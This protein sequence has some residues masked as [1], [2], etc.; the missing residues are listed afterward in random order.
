MLDLHLIVAPNMTERCHMFKTLPYN[1]TIEEP[2]CSTWIEG[3]IFMQG[4]D[5]FMFVSE[6]TQGMCIMSL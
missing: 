5:P 2:L 4:R 3:M 1:S 6:N